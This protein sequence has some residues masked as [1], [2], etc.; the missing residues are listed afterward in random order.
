MEFI[1]K[2]LSFLKIGELIGD[3]RMIEEFVKNYILKQDNI[4]FKAALL[5]NLNDVYILYTKPCY[6]SALRDNELWWDSYMT[7]EMYKEFNE[8]NGII[9]A[10]MLLTKPNKHRASYMF[11]DIIDTRLKGHN[12]AEMLMSRYER[13]NR[14]KLYITT[15]TEESK[16]YWLNYLI[17][18]NKLK[19]VN[20][21][22]YNGEDIYWFFTD[23]L[24][25]KSGQERQRFI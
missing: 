12:L 24:T 14:K 10:Y 6:R 19:D 21:L 3:S 4:Y 11:I 1:F 23:N 20:K 8:S 25:Y 2:D 22:M 5:K 17:K 15:H 7:P 18:T 13:V 9:L 16:E